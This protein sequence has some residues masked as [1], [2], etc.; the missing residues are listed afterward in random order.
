MTNKDN[1]KASDFGEGHNAVTIER[2]REIGKEDIALALEKQSKIDAIM[3]KA[4]KDAAPYKDQIVAIRDECLEKSGLDKKVW[5]TSIRLAKAVQRR[6]ES[7]SKFDADDQETI[8][9]LSLDV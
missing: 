3:A 7:L 9:Q 6:N 1:V 5:A 4:K 2:A 8:K